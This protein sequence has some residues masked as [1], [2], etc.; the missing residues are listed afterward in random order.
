[1]YPS[2]TKPIRQ[3]PVNTGNPYQD[4]NRA[5]M[6]DS[7]TAEFVPY[8]IG[9][10]VTVEFNIWRGIH[11]ILFKRYTADKKQWEEVM[12]WPSGR[13]DKKGSFGE[14]RISHQ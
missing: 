1:M 2:N 4:F 13:I 3:H 10:F 11:R 8:A 5:I 6:G 9:E 14:F 12:L 7:H